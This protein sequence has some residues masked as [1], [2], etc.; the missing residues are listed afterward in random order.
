MSPD[1]IDTDT[2]AEGRARGRGWLRQ[3]IEALV[4]AVLVTTFLVTSVGISGSSMTPSLHDGERVLVPRFET[5]LHRLG[6][7]AFGRGD[8]VYFPSPRERGPL[9]PVFCTHL[10]KRVVAIEGDTVAI[11]AGQL[12]VNGEALAE[13]YLG[14]AWRGSSELP[15]QVVPPGH[16]FVLGD[17]RGPFGSVDSR[18]FGPV[19]TRELEGRA[20]AVIWPLLRRDDAGRWAWNP[21]RLAAP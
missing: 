19:P 6:I 13:P 18:A 8:I 4:V 7:G 21:R 2:A 3:L 10:I 15:E 9:C 11:R 14:G 5:W 16:V 20:A 17:N 1:G 12:I